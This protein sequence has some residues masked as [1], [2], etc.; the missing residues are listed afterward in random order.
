MRQADLMWLAGLLEGEGCFRYAESPTLEL[1]MTDEDVVARAAQITQRNY[2]VKKNRTVKGKHIYH[3]RVFSQHAIDIMQELYPHMGARR[4][5]QIDLCIQ[6]FADQTQVNP[7]IEPELR[8]SIIKDIKMGALTIAGIA[9]KYTKP[10]G[11][12][13]SIA[14]RKALR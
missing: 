10:Y 7:R 13:Y 6:K 3:L 11:T 14:S 12:I 8:D 1:Q 4:K 5:A 2:L 9:K